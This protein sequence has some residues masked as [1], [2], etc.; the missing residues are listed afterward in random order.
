M[1]LPSLTVGMLLWMHGSRRSSLGGY[2]GTFSECW[3][4]GGYTGPK[5][6]TFEMLTEY[7]SAD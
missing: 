7:V 2:I 4:D 6:K 3:T 5:G 1:F